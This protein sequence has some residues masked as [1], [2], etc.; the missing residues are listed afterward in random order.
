[1]AYHELIYDHAGK[2]ID[3]RFIDV[4]SQYIE[5]TGVDPR[6]KTVKQVFPD[7]ENDPFDWIGTYAQ[8]VRTGKSLNFEQYF[9]SNYR[10]YNCVA[11]HYRPDQ[12]V[13]AFFEI[14]KRKQAETDLLKKM[15]DLLLFQRL[16][17]DRELKMIELKKEI[18]KLLKGSGK[19]EKYRIVE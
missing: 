4:N 11:F 10:W 9:M 17:V 8:V 12:F 18:N 15:D 1:V 5:L 13:V 14:T 2:P 19:D 16:T 6:D 7:I 3:Y